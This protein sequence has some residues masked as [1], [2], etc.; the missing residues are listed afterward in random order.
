M[1]GFAYNSN[2]RYGQVR[3][4]Q[5]Q[6]HMQNP[7]LFSLSLIGWHCCNEH[8]SIQRPNGDSRYLLLFT[9]KGEGYLQLRGRK[10]VLR[11]GTLTI[12]PRGE[13]NAYG[14]PPGKVWEF[15]WIHPSG[16]AVP[17]LDQLM[18]TGKLSVKL[19]AGYPYISQMEDILSLVSSPIGS[20]QWQLS[21]KLS[22]LLHHIAIQIGTEQAENTLS[23][24]VIDYI[25]NHIA[26]DFTLDDLA[27][28]LYVSTNHLIRVFRR[29][30]GCT[31]HW[32]L[33][34]YRLMM[35][36]QLLK[37][38]SYPISEIAKQTGYSSSSHLISQ[39]KQAHGC[40]PIQYRE[41]NS[42]YKKQAELEL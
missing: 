9:I 12:I 38:S 21:Q 31:P 22:S 25:E 29:E 7:N 4:A 8:Y 14:T 13:P 27:Q 15:Y 39:F 42:V 16:L 5:L 17:F 24:K 1:A 2:G 35:A 3:L 20:N 34:Q 28:M 36:E 33:A 10:M 32:Y 11:P 26:L 30:M 23:Q 19:E 37:F 18:N 40:T 41:M 6:E